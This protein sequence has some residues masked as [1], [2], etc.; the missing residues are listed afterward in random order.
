MTDEK[1]A[2]PALKLSSLKSDFKKEAEGEWVESMEYPGVSYLVR[3]NHYPPYQ[4]GLSALTRQLAKQYGKEPVPE[5]VSGRK[6]GALIARH[7]LLGWKG[8]DTLYD[9]DTA[10]SILSDPEYR[11]LR[12]DVLWASTK[13]AKANAEYVEEASGN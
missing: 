6:G 9:E 4:T 8:F 2:V 12:A 3:S 11:D 7:L 13:V 10:M 1:V 5:A